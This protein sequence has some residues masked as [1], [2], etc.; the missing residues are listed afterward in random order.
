VP[1]ISFGAFAKEKYAATWALRSRRIALAAS[2]DAAAAALDKQDAFTFA[3]AAYTLVNGARAPAGLALAD[4]N[5][6]TTTGAA[7]PTLAF[8][9]GALSP[10]VTYLFELTVA[11]AAGFNFDG[12]GYGAAS[13][14]TII[15]INRPPFGG[16]LTF[17]PAGGFTLTTGFTLTAAGSVRRP[18]PRRHPPAHATHG[19][20]RPLGGAPTARTRD[21]SATTSARPHPARLP[22]FLHRVCA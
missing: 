8:R 7:R 21:A 16:A 4:A 19:S 20:R 14:S 9:S 1:S 22:S 2:L 15:T 17:E 12:A 10:G 11:P 6:V 5:A 3:W 13:A 18:R